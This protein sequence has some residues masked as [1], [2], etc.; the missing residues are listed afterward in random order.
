MNQKQPRWIKR[1]S[2]VTL[3]LQTVPLNKLHVNIN[4]PSRRTSI[5]YLEEKQRLP[6]QCHLLFVV[7]LQL[8]NSILRAVTL[9]VFLASYYLQGDIVLQRY[10]ILFAIC[11]K[12]K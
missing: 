8:E 1:V 9:I 4:F 2:V 7:C 3:I 5:K 6:Q 10:K 12:A 11:G